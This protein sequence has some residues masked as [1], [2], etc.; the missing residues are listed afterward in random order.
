LQ[1]GEILAHFGG[2]EARYRAFVEDGLAQGVAS[3]LAEALASTILGRSEFVREIEETC[4]SG[5]RQ[6]RD[7]PDLRKLSCRWS[8]NDIVAAVET[9]LGPEK[10]LARKVAIHL[11]HRHCAA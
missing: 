7:I 4:L 2:D 11:C 8:V 10:S 6:S 9:T 3:P 5:T 1:Q